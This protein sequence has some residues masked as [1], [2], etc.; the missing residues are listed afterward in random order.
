M[1][2]PPLF[3]LLWPVVSD[4]PDRAAPDLRGRF[5]A[6]DLPGH[7]RVSVLPGPARLQICMAAVGFVNVWLAF[8]CEEVW[9]SAFQ[10]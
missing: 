5:V 7:M 3:F 6:P 9:V 4:L 10:I 8:P 2:L 1:S